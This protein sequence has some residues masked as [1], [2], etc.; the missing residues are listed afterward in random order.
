MA[1][2]IKDDKE[3]DEREQSKKKRK[4]IEWA[5]SPVDQVYQIVSKLETRGKSKV[6]ND[7]KE[8]IHH[9]IERS[10]EDT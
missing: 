6:G 8:W 10:E 4:I 9:K 5:W 2:Q 3:L 1:K 7:V